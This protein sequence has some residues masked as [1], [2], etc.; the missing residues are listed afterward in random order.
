MKFM[1]TKIREVLLSGAVGMHCNSWSID[2]RRRII[3]EVKLNMPSSLVA[4]S[5]TESLD[6]SPSSWLGQKPS[7][8]GRL[9]RVSYACLRMPS[10]Y[11]CAMD[12]G[13][14]LYVGTEERQVKIIYWMDMN[15]SIWNSSWLSSSHIFDEAR[16]GIRNWLR[17]SKSP[18]N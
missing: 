5:I 3:K 8:K 15:F 2:V 16:R 13:F 14:E 7:T 4:N 11:A 6:H 17:E 9:K 12:R 18:A 1:P 10:L